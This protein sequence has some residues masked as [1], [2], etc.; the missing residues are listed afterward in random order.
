MWIY[1]CPCA[2]KMCV[3]C[4]CARLYSGRW[5]CFVA[6]QLPGLALVGFLQLVSPPDLFFNE[7]PQTSPDL[8]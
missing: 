4:I 1:L 7:K 2:G 8:S 3:F 5:R 6:V